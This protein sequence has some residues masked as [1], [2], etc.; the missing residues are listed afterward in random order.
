MKD[1]T[2]YQ[3][4]IVESKGWIKEAHGFG[5]GIHSNGEN[6]QGCC[7]EFEEQRIHFLNDAAAVWKH[8][9][10][11][12]ETIYD[13]CDELQ[14]EYLRSLYNLFPQCLCKVTLTRIFIVILSFFKIRS[15]VHKERLR[16]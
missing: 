13:R 8:S 11:R 1:T 3:P 5:F 16:N 4:R 14:Y 9:S 7:R 12:V 6:Y 2:R 15:K 10:N